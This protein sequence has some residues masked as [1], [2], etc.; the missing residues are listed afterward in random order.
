MSEGSW[1]IKAGLHP[2]FTLQLP[3]YIL[4]NDFFRAP[5]VRFSGN[6]QPD[7]CGGLLWRRR[8]WSKRRVSM[9]ASRP[10][11][12]AQCMRQPRYGQRQ[13]PLLLHFPA[14]WQRASSSDA[15]KRLQRPVQKLVGYSHASFHELLL[16]ERE[17]M[18][19]K[20][21]FVVTMPLRIYWHSASTIARAVA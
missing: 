5:L 10:S 14:I 18:L 8:Y 6:C 15:T 3:T 17:Q 19:M 7:L 11:V 13:Q 21:S 20:S 12:W 9:A 2:T 1:K 4:R 16:C